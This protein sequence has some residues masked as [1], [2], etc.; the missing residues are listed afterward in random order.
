MGNETLQDIAASAMDI[1][2][3]KGQYFVDSDTYQ[4]KFSF[5][6]PG[7]ILIG[8]ITVNDN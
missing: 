2:I 3:A 6:V 4:H 8:N 5:T 1:S 7:I